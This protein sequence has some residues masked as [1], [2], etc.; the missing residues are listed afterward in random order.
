MYYS[1]PH[2]AH[3]QIL[4]SKTN[5]IELFGFFQIGVEYTFWVTTLTRNLESL[6]SNSAK[7]T[8]GPV[9]TIKDLRQVN[10]TNSS[11]FLQWTAAP[12]DRVIKWF[13]SYSCHEYFPGFKRN[14][15]V[16]GKDRV[17]VSDLSPGVTYLFKIN[18][19]LN[20][21]ILYDGIQDNFIVVKTLGYQLPLVDLIN[22]T[23]RGSVVSLSWQPPPTRNY[24]GQTDII[25][26][27]SVYVGLNVPELKLYA[28]TRD[29]RIVLK[30]LYSCEVYLVQVRLSE[31]FGI[32]PANNEHRI[33]TE[34]DPISP[35]KGLRYEA[36]NTALTKYNIHWKASCTESVLPQKIGYIVRVVDTVEAK[37]DRFRFHPN[38]DFTHSFVLH[39]HYGAVYEIQ[40]STDHPDARWSNRITLQALPM[41][42][43]YR[44]FAYITSDR[45]QVVVV[46]KTVDN[47]PQDDQEHRQ[48]S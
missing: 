28:R 14:T 46:W 40:V 11:V 2:P 7:L 43:P 27:Y 38:T 30:N 4:S 21:T 1:P 24:T 34:F 44:P 31:P 10:V 36:A 42:R 20:N 47:F 39:V 13:I 26:E 32:G 22:S 29:T 16:Y 23:I 25:W 41:P 35:P 33:K 5:Q 3:N 6:T 45:T 17:F 15:T 18:P 19:V 48:V 12:D 8:I 9:T 37:E